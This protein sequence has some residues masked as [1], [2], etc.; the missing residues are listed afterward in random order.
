IIVTAV[1]DEIVIEHPGAQLGTAELLALAGGPVLY[2]LGHLVFRLRMA[3]S[4][5]RKRLAAAAA[6]TAIGAVG[7]VV[8]ALAA[9]ALVTGALAALIVVE[10]VS[11]RRRRDRGLPSP[12]E[13]LAAAAGPAQ[14]EP[15]AMA[16]EA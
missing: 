14:A 10:K 4:V 15:R 9:A 13:R 6:I 2:L 11:G 16:E 8:P 3:G 12:L 7:T 1:G 5:S